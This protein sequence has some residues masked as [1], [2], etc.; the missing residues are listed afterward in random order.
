[1]VDK[2]GNAGENG[3]PSVDCLWMAKESSNT[4]QD[5]LVLHY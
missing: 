4:E 2:A 5:P 3:N 1:V